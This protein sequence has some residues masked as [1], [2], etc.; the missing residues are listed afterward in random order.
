MHLILWT[1]LFHNT[2][3]D[4]PLALTPSYQQDHTHTHFNHN[5]RTSQSA[6]S[7]AA[8][9]PRLP[10]LAHVPPSSASESQEPLGFPKHLLTAASEAGQQP[11]DD[12]VQDK[13]E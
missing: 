5:L 7:T 1:S 8:K 12:Q 10:P 3:T 11:S 2:R 9:P 13:G 4:K 6:L